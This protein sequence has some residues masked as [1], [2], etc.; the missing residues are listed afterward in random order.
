M[1][2]ITETAI[3]KFA[4]DLL[5]KLG[6]QHIYAPRHRHGLVCVHAMHRQATKHRTGLCSEIQS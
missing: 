4:I 3:E 1:T 6:Y 5:E 2:K